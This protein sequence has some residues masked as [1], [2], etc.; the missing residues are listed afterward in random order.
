MF[1]TFLRTAVAATAIS[2]VWGTIALANDA[3]PAASAGVAGAET[4]P[5]LIV[6]KNGSVVEGRI[7]I[8]QGGYEVDG[9][10]G[11]VF[12][13]DSYV[14]YTAE[15]RQDAYKTLRERIPYANADSHVRIAQWCID[16]NLHSTAQEELRL[17]LRLEPDHADARSMLRL[18]TVP[19]S[20][21]A[22]TASNRNRLDDAENPTLG[23]LPH[24]TARAFVSR[25]QPILVNRCGNAACHGAASNSPFTLQNARHGNPAFRAHTHSNLKAVL[26]Q[27]T[28]GAPLTSP[29]ITQPKQV[30]HG[31][32]R[33]PL[34]VGQAG[35]VQLQAL[36][37]WVREVSQTM[38]PVPKES[39]LNESDP[40]ML[41]SATAE[42]TDT[43]P[44][45]A[46]GTT[47]ADE[48]LTVE[49]KSHDVDPTAA[50]LERVIQNER[51]DAFDP[52]VF[53]RQFAPQP[54]S[55]PLSSSDGPMR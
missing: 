12:L 11:R 27:V 1:S 29:L 13:A 43:A 22:E 8:V 5:R 34:F 36:A 21:D 46:T 47:A 39:G 23:G 53:N 3:V 17:A 25:V 19:A 28:P 18:L 14:W 4:P 15:N 38:T 50:L 44:D 54:D 24:E 16:N 30:G 6:L 10:A 41:T 55:S 2:P 42:P 49:P 32:N 26:E 7:R 48:P 52:A 33:K 51:P 40:L 20:K 35:E 9:A 45:A 31:G 37:A